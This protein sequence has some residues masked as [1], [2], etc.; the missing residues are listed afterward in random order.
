MNVALAK[1]LFL[2]RDQ[3]GTSSRGRGLA[4]LLQVRSLIHNIETQLSGITLEVYYFE[5]ERQYIIRHM[6]IPLASWILYEWISH[7]CSDLY[8][9]SS[10]AQSTPP[11][12]LNQDGHSKFFS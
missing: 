1:D 6:E 8:G 7:A 11:S 9:L 3:G 5:L 12:D 2:K 10:E 4:N